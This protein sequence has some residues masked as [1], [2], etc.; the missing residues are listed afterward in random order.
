M[1]IN[2][3]IKL[4]EMQ[5]VLS[6]AHTAP[7][8]VEMESIQEPT[9]DVSGG[10]TALNIEGPMSPKKRK[11]DSVVY[12]STAL[13]VS[14]EIEQLIQDSSNF[15]FSTQVDNLVDMSSS[16]SSDNR[17]NLISNLNNKYNQ[18]V[19]AIGEV[20]KTNL[21]TKPFETNVVPFEENITAPIASYVSP[22]FAAST[23]T[24]NEEFSAMSP[25]AQKAALGVMKAAPSAYLSIGSGRARPQDVAADLGLSLLG[26]PVSYTN[27][28]GIIGSFKDVSSIPG[29]IN[30]ANATIGA[31]DMAAY[32][33][34]RVQNFTNL[35]DLFSEVTDRF[36]ETVKGVTSI[37][38][39]PK[40]ALSAFGNYVE[41]GTQRPDIKTFELPSGKVSYVFNE[42]NMLSLPGMVEI[43]M[44]LG[45]LGSMFNLSRGIMEKVGYEE[46]VSERAS[47]MAEAWSLSGLQYG[48]IT[49]YTNLEGTRSFV[50]IDFDKLNLNPDWNNQYDLNSL[51]EGLTIG[52][53]ALE[54]LNPASV[55]QLGPLDPID[56]EEFN[57]GAREAFENMARNI[58][59]PEPDIP[60]TTVAELV[61]EIVKGTNPLN[62]QLMGVLNDQFEKVFDIDP[63]GWPKDHAL[64]AMDMWATQQG[65]A[66][67]VS[68]SLMVDSEEKRNARHTAQQYSKI[69]GIAVQAKPKYEFDFEKG[70]IDE[71]D[72]D[73]DT[74]IMD[75]GSYDGG[76]YNSSNPTVGNLELAE[77]TMKARGTLTYQ[78]EYDKKD[79]EVAKTIAQERVEAFKTKD[80]GLAAALDEAAADKAQDM[81]LAAALDEAAADATTTT[82]I[83]QAQREAAA[84]EE[85]L[86]ARESAGQAGTGGTGGW[87][88]DSR[89]DDEYDEDSYF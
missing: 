3:N 42:K 47:E 62:E 59:I 50:D 71:Y 48:A 70:L 6:G 5:N 16:M 64:K 86:D 77:A 10:S 69:L 43:M 28:T 72:I 44:G 40:A 74:A 33:A 21:E 45:Q 49:G 68:D 84:A 52:E 4:Q 53:I 23:V 76:G 22:D 80:M 58:G 55:I 75:S 17:N 79:F 36:S 13:K 39:D 29:V 41:Y 12:S 1:E 54:Y 57:S 15:G 51:P 35:E 38:T 89:D 14:D 18:I 78:P 46:Q 87:G 60:N 65:Y 61:D 81:G 24:G 8:P 66:S 25:T 85:A 34:D 37:V 88:G 26:S 32:L 2:Q 9:I 7:K 83:N 31:I 73:W 82:D 20:E 63:R 27:P 30:A 67:F 11:D 56:R 19:P